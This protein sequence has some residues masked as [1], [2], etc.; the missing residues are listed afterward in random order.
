MSRINAFIVKYIP[1]PLMPRSSPN[2]TKNELTSLFPMENSPPIKERG[3]ILTA[4]MSLK[5][6]FFLATS[7]CL[8]LISCLTVL[9]N[10]TYFLFVLSVRIPLKSP[11]KRAVKENNPTIVPAILTDAPKCIA[12]ADIKD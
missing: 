5:L 4:I 2:K 10:I 7:E 1:T 3:N 8:E 6:I 12:Y 9:T 11:T